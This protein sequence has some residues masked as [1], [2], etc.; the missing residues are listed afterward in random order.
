MIMEEESVILLLQQ[1]QELRTEM[2]TQKQQLQEENNS[3]RAELQA[4]RN[5]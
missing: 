2:R 3:L 5:L 4:V 1:L